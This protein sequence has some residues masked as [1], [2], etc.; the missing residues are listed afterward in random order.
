MQIILLQWLFL[1]T[2][3]SNMFSYMKT[4]MAFCE[5]RSLQASKW[6]I[7]LSGSVKSEELGH[8]T[9]AITA[10]ENQNPKIQTLNFVDKKA[11]QNVL[12]I[13]FSYFLD[14]V[15]GRG[16][17][18]KLFLGIMVLQYAQNKFSIVSTFWNEIRTKYLKVKQKIKL[19]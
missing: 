12:N 8:S 6:Y 7:A 3:M 17:T 4:I 14:K 15:G 13:K 9:N 5:F 1:Q 11:Y 10:S 16:C 2:L 18:F 19:N